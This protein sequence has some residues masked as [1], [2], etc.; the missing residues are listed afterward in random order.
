MY[1]TNPELN[2]HT[3]LSSES[4]KLIQTQ[5]LLAKFA[6]SYWLLVE[7][8][9]KYLQWR[10]HP[11]K[12]CC[13]RV[14]VCGPALWVQNQGRKTKLSKRA[15][16]LLTVAQNEQKTQ[17][18]LP[19]SASLSLTIYWVCSIKLFFRGWW[20]L[21]SFSDIFW[22]PPMK[23]VIAVQ[24]LVVISFSKKIK[25]GKRQL[26]YLNNSDQTSVT[27]QRWQIQ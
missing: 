27:T 13:L 20:G 18:K 19:L 25:P 23:W 6:L 15:E 1:R 2:H 21:N 3:W 16:T 10:T 9:R 22:Q 11:S 26:F 14:L 7:G 4:D 24:S 5:S 17:N 12:R 8:L